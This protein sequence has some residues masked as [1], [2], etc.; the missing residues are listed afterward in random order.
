MNTRASPQNPPAS[1]EPA[2][3][4]AREMPAAKGAEAALRDSE[5]RLRRVLDRSP[6]GI[7]E[8]D[9]EGRMTLVSRRWCEML[10]Y[11][12]AELLGRSVLEVTHSSSLEAVCRAMERLA[13][14]GPDF[15]I[16]KNCQHRDGSVLPVQSSVTALRGPRGEFLGLVAAVLDA[17]E[18][19][20]ADETI[21]YQASL[22]NAV[23]QAVIATDL[24]G[25]VVHWNRFAERLYGWSAAEALGMPIHELTPTELSRG[26]A[27]EIMAALRVGQSWAGE[28]QVRRK[29]GTAF[30]ALVTDSPIFD[31]E[32]RQIG[33]VGVSADISERKRAEAELRES[34]RRLS[35]AQRMAK[36]GSWAWDLRNNAVEC[37][38]Q[39]YDILGLEPPRVDVS[40][41]DIFPFVHPDD[42]DRVAAATEQARLEGRPVPAEYRV[43]TPAGER[44]VVG[45]GEGLRDETGVVIK[46]FGTLQDI[47]DRKR[48]EERLRASEERYRRL[49]ES[50]KRFVN[51]AAHELRAPLT[52]IQGNL[53]LLARFKGM[54]KADREAALEEVGREAQRL[55]RLVADMLALARG[56]AGAALRLQPLDLAEVL[57]WAC[58]EARHLADSHRLAAELS[59][60]V[61]VLGDPD[62]LRQ[63]ALQLLEN[64]LKYT[65]PGGSVTLE[66]ASVED[67]AEF[68]VR[69]TG[70]GISPEDLPHVFERFYRADP[71]RR[72]GPDPGGTG[73]G[74]SIAESIVAQH[75]GSIRLESELGRGTV[76]T[77]RLPLVGP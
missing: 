77:V 52:A 33:I 32:G 12:E 45:T 39:I 36:V 40:A 4:A 34:E 8:T 43:L 48:A 20:R 53:E 30:P 24:E 25:R 44:W 15:V 68:R 49:A 13:S 69:D 18:R 1:P 38:A 54:K 5:A 47:T 3:P 55:G 28:F 35:E 61:L 21:R 16:E 31:A 62:R 6:A 58:A 73:L 42:R 66:L 67:W 72:R 7:V 74:L 19:R 63:L 56:D 17:T 70:V 50:Q 37:S 41:Y 10:G 23:D 75:G 76:A 64:A 2:E 11:T 26:Q 57:R 27:E 29:D 60:P 71:A 22:L 51:D 59:A 14:G 46:M 9:A 65:P